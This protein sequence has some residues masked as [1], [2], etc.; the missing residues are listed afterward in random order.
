MALAASEAGHE[1]VFAT[2]ETRH[3]ALRSVGLRPV[4]AGPSV[5]ETFHFFA[6]QSYGVTEGLRS[7]ELSEHQRNDLIAFVTGSFLPRRLTEQLLPVIADFAPDLV[8]WEC[9]NFGAAFAAKLSG[10]PSLCHGICRITSFDLHDHIVSAARNTGVELLGPDWAPDWGHSLGD[11]LLD[12]F[13]PSL[14]GLDFLA[15]EYRLELRPESAEAANPGDPVA[16]WAGTRPRPLVYLTMGTVFGSEQVLRQAVRGLGELEVDVLVATG[17]KVRLDTFGSVPENVRLTSWI[18]QSAVLP[19]ADLV[20]HHGG[21]G[22]TLG[23]VAA[24]VPQLFLPQGADHF[25][26]ADAVSG[27]GAGRRLSVEDLT[28]E[29]IAGAARALLDDEAAH[30]AA[31]RVAAEIAKMPSAKET[32]ARLVDLAP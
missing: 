31:G 13:P 26:N 20:V 17:P 16:A 22:T 12:I 25:V 18:P 2:A 14:Q 24:G 28:A 19:H 30:H 3:A 11:R 7:G 23:S 27:V 1:V 4:A 29:T 6:R 32:A 5:E 21:S 8:V 15:A 10:T 9:Y